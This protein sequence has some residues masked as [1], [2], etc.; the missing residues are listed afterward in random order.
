MQTTEK[1]MQKY[2]TYTQNMNRLNQAL[3]NNS[4]YEAI[5]IEYAT[6]EDRTNSILSDAGFEIKKKNGYYLGI[7]EKL[8]IMKNK[9]PFTDEICR[10]KCSL[11]LIESIDCWK[12]ERDNLIHKLMEQPVDEEKLQILAE[13]GKELFRELDNSVRALKRVIKK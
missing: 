13:Q 7:A 9:S 2:E 5:L 1:N 10:E 4:Y 6:I 11:E 12:K 8:K 3:Q